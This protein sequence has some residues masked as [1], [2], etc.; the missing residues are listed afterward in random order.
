MGLL[1]YSWVGY[2]VGS[3]PTCWYMVRK[4]KLF[5]ASTI[6]PPSTRTMAMPVNSTLF[7]VAAMPSVSP[8]CVAVT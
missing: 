5:H 4:S 2:K 7:W 6:I 3:I 1:D 8:W